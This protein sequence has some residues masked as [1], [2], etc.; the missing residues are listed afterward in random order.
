MSRFPLLDT[1]PPPHY[2]W[3]RRLAISAGVLALAAAV[4]AAVLLWP[5]GAGTRPPAAAAARLPPALDSGR[6]AIRGAQ[7]DL[8][9]TDPDGTHVTT[10]KGAG[11][12]MSASPDDRYLVTFSGQVFTVGSGPRLVSRP[13]AV[14]APGSSIPALPGPFADH[15]QDLILI[16]NQSGVV[17]QNLAWAFSVASGSAV[18]L[19]TVDQAA[20]DPQT[21]GAFVSVFGAPVASATPTAA[22]PDSG[23]QLN[24]A[25]QR[26]V[27][28]ATA[29]AINS[30]LGVVNDPVQLV[31]LPDPA[32]DK[33]AVVV[34]PVGGKGFGGIVV[35]NR[36]GQMLGTTGPLQ[37]AGAGLPSWSPSGSSLAYLRLGGV[38]G[39]GGRVST[40]PVLYIW[41]I[42]RQPV[43][44]QYPGNPSVAAGPGHVLTGGSCTW[45]PGGT[46]VLC[47]TSASGRDEWA[48]MSTSSR[49]VKLFPGPGVPIAWL[50]GKA[51]P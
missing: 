47:V 10:V 21:V 11:P 48:V 17:A 6:I 27:V 3:R 38:I 46:A 44:A 31:P 2:W 26:P 19:G 43:P 5:S 50:P 8:A 35:L 49:S 37:G 51:D 23:V 4:A 33:V 39:S 24:E 28:L 36:T 18:R 40:V 42:G 29:A 20:G 1:E 34:R 25:G 15:D 41:A 30:D 13:S 16:L 12:G 9:L 7:G 32:G 14:Q 22:I 45:S